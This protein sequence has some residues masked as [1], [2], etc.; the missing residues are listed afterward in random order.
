MRKWSCA[1]KPAFHVFLFK[2]QKVGIKDDHRNI[3]E[4]EKSFVF[5]TNNFE[6][7]AITIALLYKN[8][9]KIKLFFKWIKQHF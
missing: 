4:N 1:M 3:A 9:W 6:I 7:P 2:N 5:L 8:R